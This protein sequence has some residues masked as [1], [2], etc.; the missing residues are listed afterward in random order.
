MGDP[1]AFLGWI[2]GLVI[3]GRPE[4]VSPV[5]GVLFLL[6]WPRSPRVAQRVRA[7]LNTRRPLALDSIH[8]DHA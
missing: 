6:V 5:L 7:A 2:P 4:R 3:M 8:V 1:L